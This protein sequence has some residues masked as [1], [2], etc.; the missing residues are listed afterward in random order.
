[1]GLQKLGEAN[2]EKTESCA[3]RHREVLSSKHKHPEER[4]ERASS[5]VAAVCGS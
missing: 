1:M 2:T 4:T 5:A 3:T